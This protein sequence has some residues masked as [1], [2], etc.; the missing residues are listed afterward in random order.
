MNHK[1]QLF[2]NAYL[3]LTDPLVAYIQAYKPKDASN[4]RSIKSA[5][6]R[7][8]RHPE[9]AAH[10]SGVR[11]AAREQA[12]FEL[13]EQMKEELLTVHDKRLYIK[14][15]INGEILIPQDYKTNGCNRCTIFLRPTFPQILGYLKEDSRLAGHYPQQQKTTKKNLA[16]SISPEFIPQQAGGGGSDFAQN[17]P[18]P[19]QQSA[20]NCPPPAGVSR[21]DGGGTLAQDAREEQ[22]PNAV[23]ALSPIE[24]TS[25]RQHLTTNTDKKLLTASPRNLSRYEREG[26]RGT[27]A[28]NTPPPEQQNATGYTSP[29]PGDLGVPL[30]QDTRDEQQTISY[31]GR[32]TYHAG[33]RKLLS[34]QRQRNYRKTTP[35]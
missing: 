13:K 2:A 4:Y 19:E 3:R 21:S 28:Q 33:L 32:S 29:H 1:Q 11:N 30:V 9:I 8:L 12:Q 27:L 5:A 35:A 10:I 20:T 7:L 22:H 25:T 23:S 24:K 6:N 34:K 31:T 17:T 14:R 15:V 16:H 26:E 18:P